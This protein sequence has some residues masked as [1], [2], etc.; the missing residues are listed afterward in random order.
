MQSLEELKH[1]LRAFAAERDWDQFHS[2]KNLAMAISI[3]S[4]ELMEHFQW[5]AEQQDLALDA[6]R[7]EMISD[8]LA[9]VLLYTVRLAD[10]LGVD[11]L[12]A[13]AAKLVKNAERYPADK[14]RGQSRKYTEY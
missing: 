8:E 4:A 6:R 3:E 14:V 5:A 9:D 2:A 1:A 10:K 11:L 13:A 7:R 12:A